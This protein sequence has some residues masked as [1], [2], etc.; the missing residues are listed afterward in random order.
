MKNWTAS[1][2]YICA[3][4]VCIACG[5]NTVE[6]FEPTL[7]DPPYDDPFAEPPAEPGVLLIRTVSEY[8][9]AIP[10]S[11]VSVQVNDG[12]WRRTDADGYVRF[13]AQVIRTPCAFIRPRPRSPAPVSTT[14]GCYENSPTIR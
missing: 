14:F 6:L 9:R 4:S 10:V 13:A 8:N 3:T 1:L 7:Q 5:A 11:E 12:P 2:L